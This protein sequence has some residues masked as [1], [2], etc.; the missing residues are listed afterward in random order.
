MWTALQ[1]RMQAQ[2][3]G[4]SEIE[5]RRA[6]VMLVIYALGTGVMLTLLVLE[7]AFP[8]GHLGFLL[9]MYAILAGTLGT[10]CA[11]V[12]NG[13][14]QQATYIVLV[15]L[16]LFSIGT[17]PVALV[18][19]RPDLFFRQWAKWY[20]LFIVMNALFLAPRSAVLVTAGSIA[21]LVTYFF[22]FGHI[23]EGTPY[24]LMPADLTDNG[25]VQVLLGV[26]TFGLIQ[27]VS[28][29]LNTADA[30]KR[31]L[32]Q[33]V[34]ERTQEVQDSLR[35]RQAVLDHL[36]DG[37]LHFTRDGELQM[38]NEQLPALLD[39]DPTQTGFGVLPPDV[40]AVI[41][42]V[43]KTNTEASRQFTIGDRV[44][45][46]V[47]RP[48][49]T[50]RGTEFV[51]LVRDITFET[52]VDRLKT[53]FI[54]TVSHELRTPLTSILGFTKMVRSRLQK[55]VA[56]ALDREDA[57]AARAWDTVLENLDIVASEGDRLTSLINDVLD[58][59][60]MEAGRVE[61]RAEPVDVDTLLQRATAAVAGL[62][63][64]DRAV[65][66]VLDVPPSL[67][68]VTGDP[69]RLLQVLV[70]LL[71]N[72]SKF[73]EAGTVTVTGQAT[74]DGVEL[75]VTDT[76]RGIPE[77]QLDKVFDRFRQVEDTMTDKPQGTGLG[78]P[79]CLQIVHAHGGDITVESTVGAGS[80]FRFT[81][82]TTGTSSV[83]RHDRTHTP[84]PRRRRTT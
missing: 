54:A 67:G 70:N 75:S 40:F 27:A 83:D 58:I 1:R 82:P 48:M 79:I 3:A 77:N 76:G 9:T 24:A 5:R 69:D 78:L 46:V 31:D 53:D 22:A 35:E 8:T 66:L 38:I 19:R 23:V 30:A 44:L 56:P 34:A 68:S 20:S 72:A 2:Y 7:I 10:G 29:A 57:R 12:L 51:A 64:E 26:A 21:W 11:L 28:S 43:R 63:P 55:R 80:R 13:R 33:R 47:A 84:A 59:A 16:A 50:A 62:F 17:L 81:I 73:T 25:F 42:D 60:K 6:A 37:V 14:D 4:R 15:C 32:E 52:E 18:D 45:K 49:P 41:G 71:S 61:W 36:A 65:R 74:P 39:G